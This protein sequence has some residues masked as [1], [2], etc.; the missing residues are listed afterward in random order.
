[1]AERDCLQQHW[2]QKA[3]A[4]RLFC[5]VAI[6]VLHHHVVLFSVLGHHVV[7]FS[8]SHL[9]A[10]FSFSPL[11]F[12]LLISFSFRFLSG[13]DWIQKTSWDLYKAPSTCLTRVSSEDVNRLEP[14]MAAELMRTT[15][16]L[17]V[18]AAAVAAGAAA[19]CQCAR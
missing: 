15:G 2:V 19:E 11:L 10:C 8:F 18:A 13:W 9:F 7:L 14:E 1:M 16:V 17:Y 6:V 4:H 5:G 12:F 3:E